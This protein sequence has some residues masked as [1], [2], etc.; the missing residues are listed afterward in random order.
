M[1]LNPFGL[2]E[3]AI[4]EHGSS[5]ILKERLELVRDQLAKVEREKQV[6]EAELAVARAALAEALRQLPSSEFV[7]YR[8]VKFRRKPSGGYENTAYCPGCE[9]GMASTPS[10]DMPLVCGKCHALSGFRSGELKIVLAELARDY[11]NN[12]QP[13]S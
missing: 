10:G 11:P 12:E 8:G 13:K 1:E 9:S 6:L 3:K 7:A 4:N 5:A 2:L